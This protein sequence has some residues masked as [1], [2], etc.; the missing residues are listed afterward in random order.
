[1]RSNF[2]T[3]SVYSDGSNTL[4]ELAAS[5]IAQ[6]FGA[7]G[8]SEHSYTYFD[9]SYCL[10]KENT[11]EYIAEVRYLKEKYRG[12]IDIY[13][14]IEQDFYSCEE[15][16]D[17]EYIIGS[18]HYVKKDGIFLPI[19]ESA[20]DLAHFCAEYYGGD[21]YALAEDYFQTVGMWAE[22]KC[23]IIG[24]FDLITKFNEKY[25][26]LDTD[27]P[28]YIKAAKDALD[29]ILAAGKIVEINT[30]AMARGWR[31]SPYPEEKWLDYIIQRNGRLIPASDCH[32][33]K[34]L[35]YGFDSTQMK[36]YAPY[37]VEFKPQITH[38][39]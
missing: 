24:H 12:K 35:A 26:L 21:F 32:A 39:S 5:A 16:A 3:H 36:K 4:E 10:S 38:R 23:D 8:F 27:N 11:P 28:R 9:E 33:Q 6:G 29:K 7:L 20:E 2:H 13:L 25:P 34:D 30:G 31:R 14:G 17:Y 18:V 37:F 1:M 22:R 15:T 19:D